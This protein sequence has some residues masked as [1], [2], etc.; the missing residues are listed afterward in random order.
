MNAP[1]KIAGPP[2]EDEIEASRAPLME[3]LIELRKRLMWT[4]AAILIACLLCFA[5]ATHIYNIS[6]WPYEWASPPDRVRK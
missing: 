1:K 5:V 2:I 3:H 4:F 6:V